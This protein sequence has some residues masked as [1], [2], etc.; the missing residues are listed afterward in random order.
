MLTNH[1][2]QASFPLIQQQRVSL[3]LSPLCWKGR[4]ISMTMEH[5]FPYFKMFAKPECDN[6]LQPS[7]L[8]SSGCNTLSRSGLA[9]VNLRKRIFNLLVIQPTK[10]EIKPSTF[11]FLSYLFAYK[12]ADFP[13]KSKP[14]KARSALR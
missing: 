9:N 12:I 7:P 11:Q 3:H 2:P 1:W 4:Y 5:S 6:V 8:P 13:F 10:K 14:K